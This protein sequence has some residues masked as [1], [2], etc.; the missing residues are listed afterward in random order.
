MA[1][2]YHV[3]LAVSQYG[4]QFRAEI[5]TEDLGDTEGD[6]LNE[7]PPSIAEWV[8]YLAQGADLPPDAARQLG[9]DLF[10]AL[11]GQ[12]ENAKKWAEV[13]AQAT[14]KGQP[15]RL[16][17]DATTEA[18][19][20]LPYGLLCEPHDD[21]F[22]FRGGKGPSVEFVRILRR[23]SPRPL[24]L[25]DR[26]RVLVAVSE[27]TS[28]DVPPF[29]APLRLQR[30]A[31]AIH[32]EVDLIICGPN[33]AKPLSEIATDP[34]AANP[35][36]Y[37]PY[38]KT[39]RGAFRKA[40]AGDYDVLHLLAH[41]H[42]AGVLLCTDDGAPAETTAGELGEWSGAGK[43][44]L[45]F[46][47]VCKAGQTGS[48]GGFG[49]VAQQLLNPRGGN[50]AAVVASTFPLDAEHS[51]DAAVGFYRH[52]AAG[53]APAEAL[54]AERAETDWCWAFL[55]LWAR[56]GAL[57][58]TQQRAAFQFVSPYRGLSSFGEQEADLFFGRKAEVVELLQI[59]R[60]EPAVAVVGDS[61][62]GKTS[63]LQAGL[64]HAI[65]RDG[66]AGSDRWR[67]VSLR[68]GYRPAQ[69][70]L[71]ALTGS[72]PDPTP[73]AL[74]AALRVD[75]QRLMI[76]FDQFEEVFTLA[77]DKAEAQMLT[78]A[79]ADA[80]ERQSDRFRLVIGMRSEFLGQGESLRGLSR[81]IRR[82]WVL[83]PPD[84]NDIRNIVAGPAEHCGYTFQGPL[85]D[86]NPAH[87]TG[88]LDRVLADPLLARAEGGLTTA[89][90]PLLQFALERLW[91]KAVEKSVT[92]FTHAEFDEVGGMGKAIAQHAEAVYQATATATEV[93]AAGRSIAEQVIT[94][95]VSAQGTR[96]PRRRDA[97][98]AETGNP[99]AARAVVDYLVGER[100]L[101]VRTDPEDITRS[102]ADLSHEALI[103]NW[104]RLRGWLA[105]DPQGRAM[106]E[107]FRGAAEKWE[108][109]VAGVHPRS[110]FG[111]P[112]ADVARNYLAW[113]DANKPRLSPVQ[114][115]FAQ[116]M[117]DMLARLRR[118]RQLVMALLGAFALVSCV[119]AIYAV[120]QA[121][122]A[123]TSA[124]VAVKNAGEARENETK[125]KAEEAKAKA[126]KRI[127]LENAATLA[128]EKGIQ[129]CEEGRPRLGVISIAYSLQLCPPDA[130]DLRRVIL[131]NLASWGP[132]LMCLDEVHIFPQQIGGTDP[133]GKYALLARIADKVYTDHWEYI[134]EFQRYE[135]D[136]ERPAGA[137]FRVQWTGHDGKLEFR[138]ETDRVRLLPNG[139]ALFTGGGHS[140]VWDTVAG[141]PL[142]TWIKHGPGLAALRPDGKLVAACNGQGDMRL[143]DAVTGVPR[144]GTFQHMGKVNELTFS[145]DGRFLVTGCGRRAGARMD[146]EDATLGSGDTD[147]EGVVHLYEVGTSSGDLTRVLWRHLV[148]GL[149][150]CVQISPDMKRVTGGGFELRSWDLAQ[151]ALQPSETRYSP[152][153]AACIEFDPKKPS[154][155]LVSNPSGALQILHSD[156]TWKV[157]GERLTPQG[158]L[159]GVGY[160][161]DGRVFTANGEGTVRVWNRPK[162]HDSTEVLGRVFT[163]PRAEAILSVAFRPDGKAI[164]LGARTGIVFVYALDRLDAPRQFRCEYE[165][166]RRHP[167]T[168]L[169][170]STDGKRIIARDQ[171]LRVFV[172]DA[173][174][175]AAPIVAKNGQRPQGVADDGRT[176]VFNFNSRT[177]TPYLIG[178][179]DPTADVPT[180]PKFNP[181][182]E[183][184]KLTDEA[185]HWFLFR[186]TR[187]AF[188]PDRSVVAMLN[189]EGALHLFRTATGEQLCEPLKHF[190]N[191]A[192]EGIFSAV[193]C[194]QGNYL[195]TRSQRA[196]GIWSAKNGTKI[197]YRQNP[198]GI[199]V[200]RFSPSGRLVLAGTNFSQ[201]EAW[202]SENGNDA[203]PFPLIHAAQVWGV[204]A[205]SKDE[206]IIT[207]SFDHTARIWSRVH[208]RS[209]T[210]TLAHRLG[211]SDATFSP[212]GAFALTG[213]WDG[214]ARL[215]AVPP[216]LDDQQERI[217]AWVET[218]TGLR[219][220]PT[221]GG[222]LLKP[223]EWRARKEQLDRL[224]GPPITINR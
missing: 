151:G 209:L 213:S 41:G 219:I 2:P 129:I 156:V 14:R 190:V 57:G 172:F 109:G 207:A 113:I 212:D 106:R 181:N 149:V 58:G 182:G 70:L 177:H 148:P 84:S 108:V 24:K 56:P 107:E 158:W 95:L 154:S 26:L 208:R 89:P 39:T 224:G 193:F 102:L 221:A 11:L 133:E 211:V 19:R 79:L 37:T 197:V 174:G 6:L 75:A 223:E 205:D 12:P 63:L 111:L 68:P 105:E 90:L 54:T 175:D 163:P 132:H 8:P 27:P 162:H 130:R 120:D 21:W 65:R 136:T 97:L 195:L 139:V 9:K 206:R 124:A 22:L 74:G 4:E 86:G 125:A 71:G 144:D 50:M 85:S 116:A 192:F 128:L 83:R 43:S 161:A 142:G 188:N 23:C 93:G 123:R 196:W 145:A 118:R 217:E 168:H 25:P 104:D 199:Q 47:Q 30:L 185:E 146:S 112:G 82:P 198:I 94:A 157:S 1:A 46:L 100:L 201:G 110:W 153:S 121:G 166:E 184:V 114:Q 152:E 101:T 10:A 69:A 165:K 67:T 3:R 40:V 33:G 92:E 119:L 45:A 32:K 13:L 138:H 18:V 126:E 53:R 203:I 220:S 62:S 72:H 127:A 135:I 96:Q 64:V 140:S 173:A 44:A 20:D 17:V 99:A 164:A 150:T 204:A 61:G 103:H 141:K 178:S 31:A 131:T 91:L 49:G 15:V 171:M 194:S 122:K 88:L 55:E 155:F 169:A 81:L 176:A 78:E 210:H 66:L 87:A 214:T 186:A 77:R 143:Y 179:L 29:D 167:I 115:E 36:A 59:L 60:A 216:A 5:F 222:E 34:E 218:M 189:S 80:V 48:R 215:W 117:R 7:L 180:S 42:G 170:F 16:L 200:A 160:R 28:G 147:A 52:L 159:N 35:A 38:T 134:L 183:L 98:Q 191:G 187:V 202:T 73:G 137:P 76:V 51:T